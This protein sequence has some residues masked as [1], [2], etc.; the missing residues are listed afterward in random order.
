MTQQSDFDEQLKEILDFSSGET[1]PAPHK[2]AEVQAQTIVHPPEPQEQKRP[3]YEL[4]VRIVAIITVLF[5]LF[6]FATQIT[7]R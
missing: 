3:R 1:T 2:P 4:L 5:L 7:L 6:A